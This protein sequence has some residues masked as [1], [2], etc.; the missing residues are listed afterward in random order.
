V[1]YVC[2]VTVSVTGSAEIAVINGTAQ[3]PGTQ[4]A[5]FD[6]NESGQA[7]ISVTDTVEETVTVQVSWTWAPA[8]SDSVTVAFTNTPAPFIL[9]RYTVDRNNNGYLD[10]V[11]I[12][13]NTNI[14]D[15]SVPTG[16]PLGYTVSGAG[17]LTFDSAAGGLDT[18]GDNDIYLTFADGVLSSGAVPNV[19]Y[20]RPP[21][22]TTDSAANVMPSQAAAA[23]QDRAGP[24][25]IS[26]RTYTTTTVEITFS[27]NVDDA[28]LAGNHFVFAG[29]AT[30]GANAAGTGLDTGAAANDNVVI[31][32]LAATIGTDETGTV[33]LAGAGAARDNVGN[34]SLQTAPVA[35]SDGIITLSDVVPQKGDVAIVNN[36]I[37]PGAGQTTRLIYRLKRGGNVKIQVFTLSGDIV[38]VLLSARQTAGEY[39]VFWDGRNSGGRIVAKGIYFI[40]IVGPG[41]DETRKVL[42]VK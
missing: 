28:S 13:F 37:N 18:S 33:Q 26:A 8:G 14:N 31:V 19:S 30:A 6:T 20:A 40:R 34:N 39:D 4:T 12:V 25:V 2:T 9:Y 22:T 21:G 41:V 27:E 10:A 1:E 11:R 23:A 24:A 35:V 3:V 15:A 32:T 16:T 36:V 29:F 5:T 7:Y 17:A 42:V 38:A